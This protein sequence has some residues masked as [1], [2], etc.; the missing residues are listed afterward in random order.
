MNE[1]PRA[2]PVEPPAA[3][4]C[5][6]VDPIHREEKRRLWEVRW[7]SQP[8]SQSWE[9]PPGMLTLEPGGTTGIQATSQCGWNMSSSYY[10]ASKAMSEMSREHTHP[11]FSR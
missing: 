10:K 3:G 9:L 11:F 4:Q 7:L 8:G 2:R 5:L 6:L 1:Q